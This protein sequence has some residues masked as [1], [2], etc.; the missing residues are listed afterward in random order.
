[1]QHWIACY[2]THITNRLNSF[3]SEHVVYTP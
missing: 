2:G 3:D 1:M